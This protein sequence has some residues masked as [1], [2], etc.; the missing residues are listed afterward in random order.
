M[1]GKIERVPLR[2]VWKHEAYDFTKWLGDNIEILS[3]AIGINLDNTEIEAAAG[4]FNV[5]I[6]AKDDFGNYV[7]IENQLE[8]SNHDHLG[9]LI[10]YL[11][12]WDAKT[13]IWIVEEPRAEHI[14]AVNLLNGLP[15]TSFYM[16]KIE[17]VRIGNSEPAPL[18]TEIVGPSEAVQ[19]V[20]TIIKEYSKREKIYLEFWTQLFERLKSKTQLFSSMTPN[21]KSWVTTGAGIS[22]INYGFALTKDWVKVAIVIKNSDKDFNKRVFKDL[23]KNR[24]EITREFGENLSWELK[25]ESKYSAIN[26]TYEIGEYLNDPDRWIEV[27]DILIDGMVQ[28]EQAFKPWIARIRI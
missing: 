22:G 7:V 11:T 9:K 1:V 19:R 3:D 2:E 10:T 15:D 5:D 16:L 26:R 8:K 27:Q 23:E 25:P 17:A 18:L 24:D 12:M 4:S 20:G 14:K 28:M 6:V 13:A 21:K